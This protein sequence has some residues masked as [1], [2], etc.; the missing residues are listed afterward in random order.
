MY[1]PSGHGHHKRLGHRVG[2]HADIHFRINPICLIKCDTQHVHSFPGVPCQKQLSYTCQQMTT[3][4]DHADG[5][6][7]MALP[8]IAKTEKGL[9][10]DGASHTL[11]GGAVHAAHALSAV[12]GVG[13]HSGLGACGGEQGRGCLAIDRGRQ[14]GGHGR[15]Q[16]LVPLGFALRLAA[17]AAAAAQHQ[18]QGSCTTR[19]HTSIHLLV[20]AHAEEFLS[21]VIRAPCEA[22][23]PQLDDQH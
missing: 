14:G 2:A 1:P 21:V 13:Q 10:G 4:L 22:V 16:W 7:M 17:L 19:Q 18:Q 23:R 6:T 12:L 9:V 20:F 3:R 8:L 11:R 5:L 15:A